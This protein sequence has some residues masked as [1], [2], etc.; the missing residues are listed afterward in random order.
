MASKHQVGL[1]GTDGANP[2]GEENTLKSRLGWQRSAGAAVDKRAF[3][4]L[5]ADLDTASRALLLSQSGEG[6]NCALT[7]RTGPRRAER[8]VR[9]PVA[10]QA[11]A[12]TPAD[13]QAMSL[14]RT[15][16]QPG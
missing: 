14:R 16:R 6:A 2:A 3:E 5:F 8:R 10:A 4:M 1:D 7:H 9:F 13:A 11:P 15:P 12:S